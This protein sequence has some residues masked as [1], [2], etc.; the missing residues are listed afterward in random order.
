MRV[1]CAWCIREG[2]PALVEERAPLADQRPTYGICVTHRL[3]LMLG[4]YL[5][6]LAFW[7]RR[8]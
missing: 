7:S 4:R 3:E 5:R 1:L 2:E 6:T 8:R